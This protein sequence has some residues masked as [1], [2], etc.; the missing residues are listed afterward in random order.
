M[1][2]DRYDRSFDDNDFSEIRAK[3]QKFVI[4]NRN[5]DKVMYQKIDANTFNKLYC[6][7]DNNVDALTLIEWKLLIKQYCKQQVSKYR[8]EAKASDF[9]SYYHKV[10]EML[11]PI[12]QNELNK[13]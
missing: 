3:Y 9:G 1:R 12:Y 13:L 11:L 7:N 8:K 5:P 2:D 4:G 10:R 6:D